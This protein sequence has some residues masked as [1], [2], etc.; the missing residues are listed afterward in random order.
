MHADAYHVKKAKVVRKLK[1]CIIM[2]SL[3]EVCKVELQRVGQS[4]LWH[5]TSQPRDFSIEG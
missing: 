1:E 5:G 2:L 4:G 3:V